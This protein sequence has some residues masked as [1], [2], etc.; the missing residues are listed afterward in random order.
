MGLVLSL[1]VNNQYEN[2]QPAFDTAV[3]QERDAELY[4]SL[5]TALSECDENLKKIRE[6]QTEMQAIR[7]AM[8]K[9]TLE[10]EKMAF[11]KILVNVKIIN[12]FYD[13]A[14]VLYDKLPK[15]L[16]RL[17]DFDDEKEP[18]VVSQQALCKQMAR[19]IA[20]CISWDQAKMMQPHLQNDHAYFKRNL[21]K[22]ADN[23]KLNRGDESKKAGI[24]S[25]FLAEAMPFTKKITDGFRN[26]QGGAKMRAML[27]NIANACCFLIKAK[28]F[29]DDSPYNNMCLRAMIGC[30]IMYDS[31]HPSG[32]FASKDIK[33]KSIVKVLV[34]YPTRFKDSQ[35]EVNSLKSMVQYGCKTYANNASNTV[36]KLI[37]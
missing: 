18:I 35:S 12:G 36:R 24:V 29:P 31:L 26:C 7:D 34:D 21:S 5:D 19:G 9:P 8:A 33:A 30:L 14:E 15:L 25:F 27:A 2:F 11:G 28:K 16:T 32:S 13:F 6:Y 22:M 3:P 17:S 20:F 4:N 37:E 1:F 23:F 10:M